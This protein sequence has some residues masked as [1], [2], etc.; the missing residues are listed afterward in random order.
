MP[1]SH[2]NTCVSRRPL[3]H[4]FVVRNLLATPLLCT[5]KSVSEYNYYKNYIGH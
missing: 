3:F 4:L 2:Y 5:G 1:D